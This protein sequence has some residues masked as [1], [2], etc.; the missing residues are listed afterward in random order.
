MKSQKF[1][2]TKAMGRTL[3]LLFVTAA[4]LCG[5]SFNCLAAQAWETW[6]KESPTVE[7]T[8]DAV[9]HCNA[10][11]A[12]SFAGANVTGAGT[13]CGSDVTTA[14]TTVNLQ[15]YKAYPFSISSS[16][17]NEA[18]ARFRIKP[19]PQ[20]ISTSGQ[21]A[22]VYEGYLV[23]VDGEEVRNKTAYFAGAGCTDFTETHYI[24]I[25]PE[26]AP[27]GKVSPR[28]ASALSLNPAEDVWNN[29]EDNDMEEV[30]PGTGDWAQIGPG[31]SLDPAV[32]TVAWGVELGRLWDGKSAGKIRLLASSLN[33]GMYQPGSLAYSPRS[34]DTNEVNV[35]Q[36]N[37]VLRQ[38]KVPFALAD[39]L[40]INDYQYQIKFYYPSLVTG[41]DS[42]TGIYQLS[43]GATPF[44]TWKVE[45]PSSGTNWLRITET[46]N[47]A[48]SVTLVQFTNQTWS[49]T[50]GAGNEKRVESRA[51]SFPMDTVDTSKTNRL[52][53]QQVAD[54]L[55]NVAVRTSE[56]YKQFPWG[57]ELITVTNDPGGSNWVTRFT[58]N[59]STNAPGY[60]QMHSAVYPDGNWERREYYDLDYVEENDNTVVGALGFVIRPWK[61][62]P[63]DPETAST[64]LCQVTQYFYNPY[65]ETEPHAFYLYQIIENYG[66]NLA[67]LLAHTHRQEFYREKIQSGGIE[68]NLLRREVGELQQYGDIDRT[69]Q[70]AHTRANGNPDQ[71]V[72]HLYRDTRQKSYFHARSGSV[73]S[74]RIYYGTAFD[75][76]GDSY[77]TLDSG[78]IDPVYLIPF[79]STKEVYSFSSGQLTNRSLAVYVYKTN[80][81]D[82]VFLPLDAQ[83]YLYDTLGHITNITWLEGANSRVI[84]SAD[85]RGT[86][87]VDGDLKFSELDESGIETRFT[88]DSL[89]RVKTRTKKGTTN[90]VVMTF[91]YDA[92]GQVLSET[93]G[94]GTLSLATTRMFDL[95]GKQTSET[96][97][98]GLTTTMAY[99]GGGRTNTVTLP[100]GATK[101]TA[102]YL[103]RRV[104]SVTGTSVVAEF[105]DYDLTG[106][107]STEGPYPKN[108]TT[109]TMGSTNSARWKQSATDCAGKLM[110]ELSPGISSTVLSN[111]YGYNVFSDLTVKERPALDQTNG[112]GRL[113]TYLSADYA[114]LSSFQ[115]QLTDVSQSGSQALGSSNRISVTDTFY[116]NLASGWFKAT[117]GWVYLTNGSSVATLTNTTLDRVTGFSSGLKSET[118]TSDANGVTQTNRVYVDRS[119]K[120]VT[121]V[122]SGADSVLAATNLVV[123]GL[124]VSESSSTVA[125]PTVHLYDGLERE[126]AVQNPWNTTGTLYDASTGEV[127]AKTNEVGHVTRFE[128]YPGSHANAG[129]KRSETRN[130][131]KKSYFT[132]TDRGEPYQT[133]GDTVLP[134]QALYSQFGER[135]NLTT[136]RGG[137][138]WTGTNWPGGSGDSISWQFDEAT[139]VLLSETDASAHATTYSYYLNLSLKT[140]TWARSGSVTATNSYNMAGDLT[141]I[142]YSVTNT[143][144]VSFTS[145]DRRGMPGSITDGSG[146]HTLIY[147][148]FGRLISDTANGFT[149]TNTFDAVFGKS[150]VAL[151]SSG[152]TLFTHSY[153]Y[154]AASP[155]CGRL[156]SVTTGSDSQTYAYLANSDE[157]T[158]ITATG[159]TINRAYDNGFRLHSVTNVAGGLTFGSTDYAYDSANRRQSITNADG[160][161]WTFE[162]DDRDQLTGGRRY[163]SGTNFVPGQ[164]YAYLF[165]NAG[166]RTSTRR[167]T[168]GVGSG[169]ALTNSPNSLNQYDSRTVPGS[170]EVIGIVHGSATLTV[171]GGSTYRHNEYYQALLSLDN[172]GG[173]IYPSIS[174]IG[175]LNGANVTNAGNVLLPGS[176][177]SY[178]HDLDGN[179]TTDGLWN[180]V[181][182]AENRLIEVSSV[183]GVP[184]AAKRKLTFTYD[185][186]GRRATKKVYLW[187]SS[188]WATSP[189]TDLHF[190]YD[191]WNLIA[192]L[193]GS[194][195]LLRSYEW[196]MDLAGAL[197][198][199]DGAGGIGGLLLITDHSTGSTYYPCYD[200]HGNVTGLVKNTGE[201]VARYEYGPFGE[202]IRASGPFA[203]SNPFRF[204]TKYYDVE[205]DLSYYGLRYYNASTGRWLNRDPKGIEGGSNLYAFAG[206]NPLNAF[207][208]LGAEIEEEET[209]AGAEAEIGS[210]GGTQAISFLNH[211]KG[212][213]NAYNDAQEFINDLSNLA[214]TVEGGDST[215]ILIAG[216]QAAGHA[217]GAALPGGSK[218]AKNGLGVAAN[219]TVY[220]AFGN[221]G[222]VIYVGITKRFAAR[223]AE[224][225]RRPGGGFVIDRIRGLEKLSRADARKAE[226]ALIVLNGL[227]K[228]GGSLVNKINSI[229]KDNPAYAQLL[230]EG[231]NLLRKVGYP[232]AK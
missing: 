123:N 219:T 130:D 30:S 12:I 20:T 53:V 44:V 3:R 125:T 15:P 26:S 40:P 7:V 150:A 104:K 215:E 222:E 79:R 33:R 62:G 176:V 28:R 99:G 34:F 124:L 200:G 172:S 83:S 157:V 27:R 4:V 31:K 74:K 207:D 138:G 59:T 29:D 145:F 195:T 122:V 174:A 24:E 162:Y 9:V 202:L 75:A 198:G 47:G 63:S 84:Y 129:R 118:F 194:G 88:Y 178:T 91:G 184:N 32:G 186:L 173:L 212:V 103:D 110:A 224:H 136:Y 18:R 165:D 54:G 168:S 48:D 19:S 155:A 170:L 164:Q 73:Y 57:W 58:F 55:G 60:G 97:A 76:A 149:V 65:D 188:A 120:T 166:N 17:L 71:L 158:T 177:E 147:D 106:A 230:K 38:V 204:S 179:L 142:T 181:W 167:E 85:W 183:S 180:L 113:A 205:T 231:M 94:N 226:Q 117:K 216:L 126:Y 49:V 96:D 50:Y 208:A 69:W 189:T 211:V 114:T 61:D 81:T 11:Y 109:V 191:G 14:L 95:N 148:V 68:L 141:G 190:E 116:T 201:A 121:T 192:E 206:N 67:G 66:E 171:N 137:S 139:G 70:Q 193:D 140:R 6:M 221:N 127:T 128:Y 146:S 102:N 78:A 42:G 203:K 220:Q 111:T 182:D 82:A 16:Q 175:S 51:I 87:S 39:I 89:K 210:E 132:Y 185:Y 107:Y 152:T 115:M 151:K 133:W 22:N 105:Y 8:F 169:Y 135:T 213:F 217:F 199:E 100:G 25:R 154:S 23:F 37:S 5:G 153:G 72:R 143:P 214:D 209:A 93:T 131:G 98:R 80:G 144:N 35:V 10:A 90:D 225:L 36:T 119:A 161:H 163:W 41:I 77:S 92:N 64:N 229:S 218:G 112:L 228:E 134:Q 223:A 160:S 187:N 56:L 232:G 45:G 196:G 43:G 52:E 2:M 13:G 108:I 101:I 159:R 197:G 21:N 86:N 156:G 1:C 227:G 46:R